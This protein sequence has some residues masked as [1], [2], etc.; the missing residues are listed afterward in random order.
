VTPTLIRTTALAALLSGG[1]GL[2]APAL[3]QSYET[4]GIQLSFGLGLG[5]ET[6]SNRDLSAG[7]PGA[8]SQART[9]LTFGLLTETRSQRLLLEAGGQLRVLD[10]PGSNAEGN[11]FVRP[12]LRLDYDRTAVASRLQFRA[13]LSETD[14]S[15]VETLEIDLIDVVISSG[16]ATRRT[17]FVEGRLDWRLDRPFG[18]GVLARVSDVAYRDGVATGLGGTGLFDNR[19]FTFGVNARFDLSPAARLTTSLTYEAFEQDGTPGQRETLSLGNTLTIDRPLGALTISSG[20]DS[21]E[22][23]ERI[24]TS[25]GRA[26]DLPW[27]TVSGNLGLTRG[28]A[29]DTFLTG[30]LNTTYALPR[31]TLSFGLSRGVSSGNE[32]D[33]ERV[34]NQVNLGY[35]QEIDPLSN[36]RLGANWAEVEETATGV[37]S[38]NATLSATYTRSLTRD[39]NMDLGYRHRFRDDTASG[40]ARSN[41]VFFNLRRTFVTRF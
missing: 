2:A 12:S 33:T 1:A 24:S 20:I 8:S 28:V 36:L 21:T 37:S 26:Y 6:Q 25:V 9:D 27:G 38:T 4:G 39:W 15:E 7:D 16:T 17:A 5:L 30:A 19:R 29:G 40:S 11:G 3:A 14:V 31:G 18:F 13:R 22:D 23:G 35:L 41:E 32:E 10:T 34:N